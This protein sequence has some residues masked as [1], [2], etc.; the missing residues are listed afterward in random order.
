[1]K[2]FSRAL[3]ALSAVTVGLAGIALVGLIAMMGWLVFGRYVLNDT[4]TWIERAATLAILAI[5]MPVAAVG[6]R[7]RFH[8]SV[9]GIREMLPP[10]PQR[11]IA[12][13]CDALMGLFG[14]G[15]AWWSWELVGTVAN[16]RI[17]LLGISQGW[18][19]APMVLGGALMVL[20]A[21]EQVLKDALSADAPE[22][23]GVAAAF[24]D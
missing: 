14:A 12:V 11:W 15:M 21:I 3:D 4:P 2:A 22:K 23:R 18:T 1:M 19:Y 17:P 16:F 6:V 9:L 10:G 7:E 24:L 20:F 13:G 8:L 5:A